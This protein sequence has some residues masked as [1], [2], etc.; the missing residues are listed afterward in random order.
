MKDARWQLA[1]DMLQHT[2]F[3]ENLSGLPYP[4][5]EGILNIAQSVLEQLDRDEIRSL[6]ERFRDDPP[7]E[8]NDRKSRGVMV[9]P[10]DFGT[11]TQMPLLIR[12]EDLKTLAHLVAQEL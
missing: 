12:R 3:E 10:D 1:H 7:E 8:D 4:I 2:Q 9:V 5:Q 11:S 6:A